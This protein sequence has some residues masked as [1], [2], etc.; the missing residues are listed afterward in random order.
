MKKMGFFTVV[1]LGFCLLSMGALADSYTA[2]FVV[3][4]PVIDGKVSAGEWDA[5]APAIVKFTDH[6]SDAAQDP[7]EPTK[8]RALYSLKGLYILFEC[9]DT[10]V[11][12]AAT[13]TEGPGVSPSWPFVGTDY[14]AVYV[15]PANVADDRAD[16]P[17]DPG[18]NFY[19][20]S[21]QA[22]PSRVAQSAE[23]TFTY[24]EAGRYGDSLT[25]NPDTTAEA[26]WIKGPNA[27]QLTD[28]K[29]FDGKTSD[30]YVMEYFI[31]WTDL[32]RPYYQ[33]VGSVITGNAIVLNAADAEIL[34][35]EDTIWGLEA[36]PGGKVTGMP[37]AGAT[38]KIQFARHSASA[39]DGAGEYVNWVGNTNGFVSRPFGNLVF[40]DVTSSQINDAM[41]YQ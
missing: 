29:V 28:G 31:P 4:P 3:K 37:M 34:K 36:A 41:L 17:A 38:W 35:A 12:S 22:E 6:G 20:Y 11:E 23:E 14:C 19:S 13:G 16:L 39:N 40:G 9:T 10:L 7:K 21:I 2:N 15:D 25:R 32:N 18:V 30:G 24:T 8:V 33:F 26:R 1:C 5:A 27:W